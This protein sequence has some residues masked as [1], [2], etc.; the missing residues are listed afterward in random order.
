M[1][2]VESIPAQPNAAELHVAGLAQNP[3]LAA[4]RP[5]TH[6]EV[7]YE[8][9]L[10]SFFSCRIAMYRRTDRK[11]K[12]LFLP[13]AAASLVASA[14]L[15]RP[16]AVTP[17]WAPRRKP[18]ACRCTATFSSNCAVNASAAT[19]TERELTEYQALAPTAEARNIKRVEALHCPGA[20][21]WH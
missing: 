13:P 9:V 14:R 10:V 18:P 2:T 20:A 1:Q 8:V 5:T 3:V 11:N 15:P 7:I 19:L 12:A 4:R 6:R 16:R 21:A 17:C